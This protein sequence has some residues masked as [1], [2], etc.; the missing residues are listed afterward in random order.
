MMP[1]EVAVPCF[2]A[3]SATVFANRCSRRC[4]RSSTLRKE[5]R[6]ERQ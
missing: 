2:T 4:S 5:E 3:S 6:Y 1:D